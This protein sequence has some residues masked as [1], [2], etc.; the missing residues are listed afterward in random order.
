MH[1]NVSR[2]P[3]LPGALAEP[4]KGKLMTKSSMYILIIDP[5]G[6]HSLRSEYCDLRIQL[7]L[8]QGF[9]PGDI[10]ML[11]CV[12]VW[13]KGKMSYLSFKFLCKI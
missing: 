12:S 13:T 7:C 2:I 9:L 4:Q 8:L 10:G 6:S 1:Q 5:T 11:C 3:L